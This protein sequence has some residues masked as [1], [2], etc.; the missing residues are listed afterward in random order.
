LF[1]DKYVEIG[2]QHPSVVVENES[3]HNMTL[4]PSQYIEDY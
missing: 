3:F 2:W 1:I 4:S